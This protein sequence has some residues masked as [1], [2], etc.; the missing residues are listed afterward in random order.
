M[1]LSHDFLEHVPSNM[2][3][4]QSQGTLSEKFVLWAVK[5]TPRQPKITL[6]KPHDLLDLVPTLYTLTGVSETLESVKRS[7]CKLKCVEHDVDR[8]VS[9]LN[10]LIL[11]MCTVLLAQEFRLLL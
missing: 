1:K 6:L 7:N 3:F 10:D 11:M 2:I 8:A 4:C 9:Q 5:F